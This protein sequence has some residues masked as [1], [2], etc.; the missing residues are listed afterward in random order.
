MP[1]YLTI[2]N[3]EIASAGMEWPTA[4]GPITIRLEHLED[5]V[6]AANE[7]PHVQPPRLKIGHTDPRFNSE[8][9]NDHDPFEAEFDGEPAVGQVRNLRL[10]NDGAVLVGDYVNVPAWLAE[11]MPSAYPSRSMEGSYSIEDGPAGE[12]K[13]TWDVRTPGGK[14]YSL[15]ITAVSLLG[16]ARPAILNLEDLE[17]FLTSG[18]GVT[19]SA[20]PEGVPPIKAS[21]DI[22]R[23]IDLFCAE[24]ASGDRY[25][26]WPAGV[27]TE[28]NEIIAD[29]NEGNLWAIP[30]DSNSEQEV[31]FGEP[32]QVMQTFEPAPEPAI[33]RF[34]DG[35]REAP[36]VRFGHRAESPAR[37]VPAAISD[38]AWDGSPARFTDEQYEASCVIDRKLCGE[39][40]LAPK[41]R[42]SLPIKEP[43]GELNRNAVHAAAGRF[44]SVQ[45]CDAAKK[46]GAAKLRAAY[47]ALGE[48]P[49]DSITAKGGVRSSATKSAMD[50]AAELRK[51]LGLEASASDDEVK[52]ALAAREGDEEGE[53]GTEGNGNGESGETP[54]E[55]TPAEGEQP[56]ESEEETET[57][58]EGEGTEGEGA[59]AK[60]TVTVDA[61]TWQQTRND[62]KAGAEARR[63]QVKA[64]R[65]AL[66]AK[67][68]EDGKFAPAR[69]AHYRQLHESDPEGTEQLINDLEPGLVP[70]D[71]RGSSRDPAN[72]SATAV[73]DQ[74][75]Q[76]LFGVAYR[77][78]ESS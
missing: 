49:P 76:D 52:A 64:G 4:N 32:R 67:A 45:A 1:E 40:D 38:A 66:I 25:W 63:E 61:E 2:P 60:G 8:D 15:V 75:M 21:A 6:T 42:C 24:Y 39:G 12:P 43:N 46:S 51:V 18:E 54:A 5:A 56:S 31:S 34:V 28:P 74:E 22:D 9:R 30:F 44:G 53:T 69:A 23:V 16:V 36:A 35:Y 78:R 58:A 37:P 26:W 71:E 59:A 47:K 73:T 33:A 20:T 50:P 3:V 14:T 10:V 72:M 29:D 55:G 17:G 57:P 65:D 70:L 62:A 19:T 48:E 7:D 27:W 11:A 68:V 13:G 41:Q 77:P